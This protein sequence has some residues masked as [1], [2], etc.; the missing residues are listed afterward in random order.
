MTDKD[1]PAL[2]TLEYLFPH[3]HINDIITSSATKLSWTIAPAPPSLS[4]CIRLPSFD[5]RYTLNNESDS[6]HFTVRS[7]AFGIPGC[8][9]AKVISGATGAPGLLFFNRNVRKKISRFIA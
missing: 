6:I 7:G 8:G 5:R 3:A 1:K 4:A 2:Y 9:L